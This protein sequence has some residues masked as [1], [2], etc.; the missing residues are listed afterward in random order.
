MVTNDSLTIAISTMYRSDTAFLK[1]I[2]SESQLTS[3]NI[4]VV[5]Q[6]DTQRTIKAA[7]ANIKIINIYSRGLAKSRNTA[8]EN[9]VTKFALLTDD[10]VI[11][12]EDIV[13]TLNKGFTRF[14]NAAVIRFQACKVGNEPFSKNYPDAPVKMMNIFGIMNSSSIELAVNTELLNRYD[15]RFDELFGLGSVFGNA[16]EQAFLSNVRNHNLQ[17]SYHPGFIV[18]HP[19]EC[20]GKDASVNKLYY[21]NGALSAKMFTSRRG[22]WTFIFFLFKIKQ[23]KITFKNFKQFFNAYNQGIEDYKKLK[24]ENNN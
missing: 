14:E 3:L 23:G 21:V 22:L 12:R 6:T 11:I 19:A 13:E 10:D 15:I 24:S 18:N 5:N 1:A 8:L 17:I 4:L 9:I 7:P 2:F 20:S 16:L